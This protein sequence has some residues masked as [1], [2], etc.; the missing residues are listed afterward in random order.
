MHR[1]VGGLARHG[2]L[3]RHLVLPEELAGTEA[4][5][6]FLSELSPDTAV[7]V[8]GQYRPWHEAFSLPPLDRRV[9]RAEV[10]AAREMA[11]GAGL[12]LL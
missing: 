4:V 11:R 7:N 8:M 3:V 9:T 5:V 2:L 1:Q 12:R 6:A 10:A